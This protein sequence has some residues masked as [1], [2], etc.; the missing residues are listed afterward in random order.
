MPKHFAYVFAAYGLWVAA[1]AVYLAYL[2]H[3]A[4]AARRALQ[5]MSGGAQ[6]RDP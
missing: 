4:G 6:T 1:F 5:R 2:R 3:K